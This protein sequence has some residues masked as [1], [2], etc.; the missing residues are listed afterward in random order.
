MNRNFRQAVSLT[1][2]LCMMLS[3]ASYTFAESGFIY[4]GDAS[5]SEKISFAKEQSAEEF[6]IVLEDPKP[7]LMLGTGSADSEE[8]KIQKQINRAYNAMDKL[9]IDADIYCEYKNIF[10]GFAAR[11]SYEDVKA[12]AENDLVKAVYP[13]VYYDAPDAEIMM[14]SVNEAIHVNEVYEDGN[15]LKGSGMVVAVIDTGIALSHVAFGVYDGMLSN[16]AITKAGIDA[17]TD[18]YGYGSYYSDKI[19]FGYNYAD[20][21][22][23]V[24]DIQLHGTHVSGTI[25]GYVPDD[26]P[27]HEAFRGI[28][29][30]AQLLAMKAF[31]DNGGGASD[32]DIFRA[33]DD[34]IV[35]GAD[36]INLSLGSPRGFT[37]DDSLQTELFGNI[38]KRLEEKGIVLCC[39]A[40]NENNMSE[41]SSNFAVQD[42]KPYVTADYADY[43]VVGSPSTNDGNLSIASA[44]NIS[45]DGYLM[46]IYPEDGSVTSAAYCLGADRSVADL[47]GTAP[48]LINYVDCGKASVTAEH[49]D[50]DGLD[51]DG[52]VALIQRGGDTFADKIAR[53]VSRGAIAVMIYNN[54]DGLFSTSVDSDVPFV[55]LAKDTGEYLRSLVDPNTKEAALTMSFSDEKIHIGRE[56]GL[57]G[58]GR[59]SSFSSW[60]CTPDLKL[61]PYIAGIG[62]D[63]LSAKGGTRDGY[64]LMSGT[65]MST[66][67]VAGCM[68]L[69]LEQLRAQ[70]PQY[71]KVEIAA[72]AESII[73]S[74]TRII[75]DDE[76]NSVP[77]SPRVQ[78]TGLIDIARAV[79]TARNISA[80]SRGAVYID[81]A[82]MD[83]YDSDEGA[84]DWSFTIEN[85]E[86]GQTFEIEPI[87][88]MDKLAMAEY[89]DIVSSALDP[90]N[91]EL[92]IYKRDH[93]YNTLHSELLK[94][95]ED[96]I[97]TSTAGAVDADGKCTVECH[98]ELSSAKMLYLDSIKGS[99]FSRGQFL[100][101]FIIVKAAGEK[102]GLCHGAFLGFAGDW[103]DAPVF[104]Q[105]DWRDQR[106][107][108]WIAEDFAQKYN[109]KYTPESI[110]VDEDRLI[111]L[112]TDFNF[113][114]AINEDSGK[115]YIAGTD[116]YL[117]TY[118][119]KASGGSIM[120]ILDECISINNLDPQG[121]NSLYIIPMRLRNSRH[122]YAIISD[123]ESGK[124]YNIMHTQYDRKSTYAAEADPHWVSNRYVF[125]GIDAL[126]KPLPNNTKLQISFYAD[127]DYGEDELGQY[128]D[129]LGAEALIKDEAMEK[130]CQWSFPCTI[131]SE[132]PEITAEYN[133]STKAIDIHTSDNNILTDVL[134][135]SSDGAILGIT[136]AL[137]SSAAFSLS[138]LSADSYTFVAR[139]AAQNETEAIVVVPPESGGETTGPAVEPSTGSGIEPSTGPAIEPSP[140]PAIEP[141]PQPY[142][143][144][145][146]PGKPKDPVIPK[147]PQQT[148]EQKGEMSFYDVEKGSWY[149][150]DV[151]YVWRRSLI[152]GVWEN[153]FAPDLELSRAM[154]LTILYRMEESPDVSGIISFPDIG[155]DQ[156]YTDALIWAVKNKIANGYAN[157]LFGPDDPISR[158]DAV[159][160]LMRY[161]QY[162][163]LDVSKRADLGQYVDLGEAN[164]YALDALSWAR[165]EELLNGT[166]TDTISPKGLISR[167]QMAALVH[168]FDLKLSEKSNKTQDV[169]V[170]TLTFRN[171]KFIINVHVFP[172]AHYFFG[173]FQ[174]KRL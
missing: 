38:F 142:Y 146:R 46:S 75:M 65:S 135:L 91:T 36:I 70:F 41:S 6:I 120:P 76:E 108:R 20:N 12:L 159:T 40:G 171:M 80:A 81:D 79:R 62:G 104:E 152:N 166:W 92:E 27:V 13:V 156:Y 52:K 164:D 73:K 169:V 24:E 45:L 163:G 56:N 141:D 143:P 67:G 149:F 103:T 86:Q 34:A 50:F 25:L 148:A 8:K 132:A 170:F 130:Y 4:S 151:D 173:F 64:V 26:D 61:K 55:C 172:R 51:L 59:I 118:F 134:M 42:G 68:A 19:P 5:A 89:P 168:R 48:A 165:A 29:P 49:N 109:E 32:Y 107:A 53:A 158:E 157:G 16:A 98:L 17:F 87:A 131:D 57:A 39:S 162:K 1:L 123:A 2:V 137:T 60:G 15:G 21:N 105:Y 54:S 9:G 150:D 33:L 72:I 138:D 144:P 167:S 22:E 66:P 154:L 99:G 28:A 114:A 95:D 74:T 124:V 121:I 115:G 155:L 78:G 145:S 63:V 14:T 7:V 174:K 37:Y 128:V 43:G 84:F 88:L 106:M 102:S 10:T 110:S 101:G 23:Q 31:S 83:L 136:P 140:G 112:N 116:P 44:E 122:T 90:S 18:K 160:I 153:T 147:D 77:F 125:P 111:E 58:A 126:D 85:A 129:D 93:L 11:M 47:F 30:D 96:Y 133:A 119:D 94:E 82:I 71:T 100:E 139:D 127:I 161:A 97:F 35:L 113:A 3:C 117:S 69:L